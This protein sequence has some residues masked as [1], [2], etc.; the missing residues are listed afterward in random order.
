MEHTP[1]VKAAPCAPETMGVWTASQ[2]SS[3]FCGGR[4]WGSMGSVSMTVRP[5]TTACA[6]RRLTCVLVSFHLTSH[7]H[8]SISLTLPWLSRPL[9]CVSKPLVI[10]WRLFRGDTHTSELNGSYVHTGGGKQWSHMCL[11]WDLISPISFQPP[12]CTCIFN[13]NIITGKAWSICPNSNKVL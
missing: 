10:Y 7:P 8:S 12:I 6:A 11:H 9:T 5:D 13:Y 2:N 4:G 3:Y 1:S